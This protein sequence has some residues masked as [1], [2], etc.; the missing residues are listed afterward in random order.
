M[1]NTMKKVIDGIEYDVFQ[2]T[3]DSPVFDLLTI[4]APPLR[5]V[6]WLE[7]VFE[8]KRAK[9]ETVPDNF[10]VWLERWKLI[11]SDLPSS[12]DGAT[13]EQWLELERKLF[14]KG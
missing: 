2:A 10:K 1:D 3:P 9:G 5:L 6:A 7:L 8:N 11:R 4:I 12:I 13:E 14:S